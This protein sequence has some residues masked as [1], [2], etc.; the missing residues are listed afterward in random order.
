MTA[1]IAPAGAAWRTLAVMALAVAGLA[2]SL[3]PAAEHLD[4]RL[5]DLEW[6]LLRKFALRPAPDDILIVGVDEET[7][8]RVKEP[9][10][11]WHEPLGKALARIA[12]ARPRAIGLELSLPE[13]SFDD[14][15]PGLDRALLLGLAAARDN[16]PFVAA[17]AI[18]PRTRSAR[19]VH[20][21]FLAVLREERLGIG[22][23]ARDADGVTRRFSLMVP[24]ED[25]GFPTL[26][27][28]LC[29]AL[30]RDCGDGYLHFDLGAPF[31]YIPLHQVLEAPDLPALERILRGRIVL[32][33]ETQPYVDRI[34][35]PVA[36]ANWE[37]ASRGDTPAIVVQAL[38][39]RTALLDAAPQPARRPWAVLLAAA[40]ALIV[41]LRDWRVAAL[42]AV[43]GCGILVA[44]GT[45]ALRGGLVLS[46]APAIATAIAAGLVA[47]FLA[48][49]RRYEVR[50]R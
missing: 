26:V 39:L 49:R 12:A 9:P 48:L 22:L 30:Q 25:G 18:D 33:G 40:A 31:R 15:K 16:G 34:Q 43:A 24:T 42:A 35:V 4:L 38:A 27:G 44:V 20:P 8:R 21:P 17:L 46:L 28:R 29:R 32:I 10:G 2:F 7:L 13:R 50:R 47:G 23:L 3:T 14:T 37:P 36:Y 5:L 19:P 11:L 45:V 1:R 6:H 41:L